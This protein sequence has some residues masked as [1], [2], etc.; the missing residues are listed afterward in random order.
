MNV[1]LGLQIERS[2]SAN[3]LSHRRRHC[4]SSDRHDKKISFGLKLE[5]TQKSHQSSL[6]VF[7]R[8]EVLVTFDN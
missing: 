1:F 3:E 6:K 2:R 5:I 7:K 8:P 4:N